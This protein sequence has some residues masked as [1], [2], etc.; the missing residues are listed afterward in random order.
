[1]TEVEHSVTQRKI[2]ALDEKSEQVLCS[3]PPVD[4]GVA[5]LPLT[6]RE[7]TTLKATIWCKRYSKFFPVFDGD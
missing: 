7:V 5:E 3:V 2:N 4:I 6:Y 1:M